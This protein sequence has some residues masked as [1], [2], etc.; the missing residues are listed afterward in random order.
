MCSNISG[1]Y[2]ISFL[3]LCGVNGQVGWCKHSE[4]C[5]H[6]TLHMCIAQDGGERRDRYSSCS[7]A[8][9]SIT[10]SHT[11]LS[12]CPLCLSKALPR[13]CHIY[14]LPYSLSP[15]LCKLCHTLPWLCHTLPYS[16][17]ALSYSAILS[18]ANNKR[19]KQS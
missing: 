13:P 14:T 19:G 18:H 6:L 16:A 4:V 12:L 1:I 17:M 8:C 9:G 3:N 15:W 10:H 7:A 5:R 11:L 2:F